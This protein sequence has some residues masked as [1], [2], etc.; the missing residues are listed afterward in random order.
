MQHKPDVV[1]MDLNLSG[2]DSP[3]LITRISRVNPK[4][5]WIGL[6]SYAVEQFR[7]TCRGG[8]LPG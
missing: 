4:I 3:G 7:K 1:I 2:I 5:R 8:I 6:T